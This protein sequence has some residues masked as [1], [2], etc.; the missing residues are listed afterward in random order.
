M[1]IPS[2]KSLIIVNISFNTSDFNCIKNLFSSFLES[3]PLDLDAKGS[4]PARNIQI[5][6]NLTKQK[7]EFY[8]T[9]RCSPFG[10]QIQW[11][12]SLFVQV[13]GDL[14]GNL[15]FTR[16]SVHTPKEPTIPFEKTDFEKVEL[17]F[18]HDVK[19]FKFSPFLTF[20]LSSL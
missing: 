12:A 6:P 14:H 7:C 5:E 11:P 2:I 4:A 20:S 15:T 10:V 8:V 18:S 1:R 16:N 3:M 19:K 13:P 17:P 9:D